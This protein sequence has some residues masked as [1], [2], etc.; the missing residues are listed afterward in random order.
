MALISLIDEDRQWFKSHFGLEASETPLDISFCRHAIEEPTVFVVPDATKDARFAQNP[1]VTGD[2]GIRFY[3]GAPL[4]SPRGAQIGT[5]CVVDQLP[6]R[7]LRPT[8][9]QMLADL[10]AIVIDQMELRL[11][12]RR[13]GRPDPTRDRTLDGSAGMLEVRQ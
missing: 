6:R 7:P 2:P 1:I 5:L 11:A 10:A 9:E 3:A 13:A 4:K 8:E 12:L